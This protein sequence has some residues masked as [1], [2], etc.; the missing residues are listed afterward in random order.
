MNFMYPFFM[1]LLDQ[2]LAVI[3]IGIVGWMTYLCVR[4]MFKGK[5][6]DTQQLL[7]VSFILLL[8]RIFNVL[9]RMGVHG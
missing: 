1:N 4:V 6:E 2:L 5:P 8:F 3:C 7:F 9:V